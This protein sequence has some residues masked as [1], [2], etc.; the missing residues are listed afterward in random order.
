LD[1]F[2]VSSWSK[3]ASEVGVSRLEGTKGLWG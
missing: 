1:C 2:R 3:C